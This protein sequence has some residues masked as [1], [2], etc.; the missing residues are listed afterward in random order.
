MPAPRMSDTASQAIALQPATADTIE[1]LMRQL[2]APQAAVT[3]STTAADQGQLLAAQAAELASARQ[4]MQLMVQLLEQE[5]REEEPIMTES[6]IRTGAQPRASA[7]QTP[8]AWQGMPSARPDPEADRLAAD[9][10]Q[11]ASQAGDQVLN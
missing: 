1:H 3:L 11:A 10:H 5:S 8:S 9:S 6:H 4:A 7:A 2:L